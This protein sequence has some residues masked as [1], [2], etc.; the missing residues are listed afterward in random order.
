MLEGLAWDVWRQPF[1]YT[2]LPR[3]AF[4]ADVQAAIIFEALAHGC[5]S[6]TAYITIHNMCAG[7]IDRWGTEE[8][9]LA[10]PNISTC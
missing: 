9:Q 2:F 8:Q 6:T 3:V 1:A 10:T 4:F 7:M 5:T